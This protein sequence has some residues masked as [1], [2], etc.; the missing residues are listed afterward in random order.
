MP[1]PKDINIDSI[2]IGRQPRIMDEKYFETADT[3]LLT[4]F[5]NR[6]NRFS[7]IGILISP[8]I[9][10]KTLC[11]KILG[12]LKAFGIITL[13]PSTTTVR[14]RIELTDR[15]L[16]IAQTPGAYR[17][18][19]SQ[20]ATN[21]PMIKKDNLTGDITITTGSAPLIIKSGDVT[22]G[23]KSGDI[24]IASGHIDNQSLGFLNNPQTI[25]TIPHT[26]SNLPKKN[27]ASKLWTLISEN[28]LIS[29]LILLL[30]GYLITYFLGGQ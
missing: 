7:D 9:T 17:Q 21:N 12:D 25:K 18:F 16:L 8:K 23:G 3:I 11:K 24:N 27:I 15:G 28:A 13:T 22:S 2:L 10:D 4:T 14:D 20:Q 5:E 6:H 26:I 29:G 1:A 30:I 19:I